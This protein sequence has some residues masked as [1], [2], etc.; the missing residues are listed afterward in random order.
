MEETVIDQEVPTKETV[1]A[2]A[3]GDSGTTVN[4][5]AAVLDIS[6]PATE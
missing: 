4:E 5:A 2:Q 1:S 3:D 6:D